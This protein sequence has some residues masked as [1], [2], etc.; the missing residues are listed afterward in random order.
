MNR[1]KNGIQLIGLR[2]TESVQRL[3]T[4]SMK[5]LPT[6]IFYPIYDWHDD[7]VWLY[8][9]ENNLEFPEIYIRL[10]EAGVSRQK[11]RLCSFFGDTTVVGLKNIAETD[12]D[13]WEKIERR[14]PNA[15]LVLLYWDSEM[16][17]RQTRKRTQLES[18]EEKTDYKAKLYDILFINTDK[19]NIPPETKKLLK[20][21]KRLFVDFGEYIT[22]KLYKLSCEAILCGDP[23]L[24]T[25][26]AIYNEVFTNLANLS[27]KEQKERDKYLRAAQ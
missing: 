6:N 26:R 3:K 10:Y 8:I 17:K 4:I 12:P 25:F 11:L 27:R 19:Y 5:K 18:A 21:W 22:H 2:A 14:Y 9:K 1:T 24:R 13:L 7:D 23:K 16:F 15:Y 20:T